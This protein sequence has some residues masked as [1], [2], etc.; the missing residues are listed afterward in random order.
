[1]GAHSVLWTRPEPRD[2]R[3]LIVR[4][5]LSVSSDIY[6]LQA[7]VVCVVD[8]LQAAVVPPPSVGSTS[9]NGSALL[10]AN[11]VAIKVPTSKIAS[12]D[13]IFHKWMYLP[14]LFGYALQ[15][16]FAI[17]FVEDF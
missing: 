3:A 12:E 4:G 8:L 11:V 10:Q 15:V 13:K 6:C 9:R 16:F 7:S 17:I 2:L 5:M 14:G 1:M